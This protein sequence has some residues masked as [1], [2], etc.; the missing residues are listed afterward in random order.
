MRCSSPDACPCSLRKIITDRRAADLQ[1]ESFNFA[2]SYKMRGLVSINGD[3][4]NFALGPASF[5]T[6]Q[7]CRERLTEKVLMKT[8]IL[9][10]LPITVLTVGLIACSSTPEKS[11]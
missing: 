3:L 5:Q 6:T 7:I 4:G 8:R 1:R 11:A 10:L 9:A 2:S